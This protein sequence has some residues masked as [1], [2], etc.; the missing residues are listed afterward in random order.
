MTNS[1][2]NRNPPRC[3]IIA[4]FAFGVVFVVTILVLAVAFPKPTLFQ[5][6]VFRIVL[7]LACAGV[8]AVMPGFLKLNLSLSAK[9]AVSAGGALAVFLE[10][11]PEV[12][13]WMGAGFPASIQDEVRERDARVRIVEGPARIF[14]GAHTTGMMG[15]PIP[16]QSLVLETPA[17]LAVLTR[18]APGGMAASASASMRWWV[19]S[20][21]GAWTDTT[22]QART[23][24]R[25]T[26]S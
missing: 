5:Y 20:L 9:N 14:R 3:E 12:E 4:A 1:T 23:C 16:E 8:A 10:K 19:T 24:A 2:R 18:R 6:N 17:G 15:H 22:S 7:A 13:V 26:C 11:N 21:Y 25:S